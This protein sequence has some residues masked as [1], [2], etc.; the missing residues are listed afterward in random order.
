MAD[1]V[2]TD[3]LEKALNDLAEAMGLS[4]KEF[5]EGGFLDKATYSEDHAAVVAR[6]DA[7]DVVDSEDD[8]ESIAEKL[9]AVRKVLS[10]DDGALQGI[11]NL[12]KEN[13]AAI[14]TEKDRAE[15]VEAGLRTDVDNATAKG[16]SNE[17]AIADLKTAT[18]DYATA[19]D[20]RVTDVEGRITDTEAA[21]NTLNADADTAGSVAKAVADEAARAK[22]VSGALA[23]LT[24]DEKD[25]LV[26]AINEVDS[27][28]K[29]N[30]AGI[31]ALTDRVGT[32]E[33]TLT[34]LNGD[35]SVTGSVTQ[36]VKGLEDKLT[37]AFTDAMTDAK[38][39]LDA[40]DANLQAQITTLNADDETEGSV[41]YK[42]KQATGGDISDL[43]DRMDATE[44]KT[45]AN[46]S[47]VSLLNSDSETEGS[48]DYKIAQAANTSNA[49]TDALDDRIT[50]D[51]AALATLNGDD[52][53]EGSVAKQVKDASDALTS[54]VEANKS[55]IEG[56]VSELTDTV[57][58]N[59]TA[60][61]DTIAANATTAS[62]ALIAESKR[63]TDAE[64]AL[65]GRTKTV[66]DILNDTTDEDDNL[67]KGIVTRVGDT[68]SALAAQ[69]QKQI[70]DLQAAVDEL[71]AYSDS[72]D[73][74]AAS[75]DICGVHNKF[76]S[77][78]G[79][80]DKDCGGDGDGEAV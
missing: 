69:A 50:A 31:S 13:Q 20:E 38:D 4:V 9:I 57:A 39:A 10:D 62:D 41:D 55:A 59:K 48:V 23:D 44:G 72:R 65:A 49:I 29:V 30:A 8:I 40:A 32:N 43:S 37:E 7:I 75:M 17:S 42:I 2:T 63:A 12:I 78:L 54:T 79:L 16:A 74:K 68:E 61:E 76:R 14:T 25:T 56:T 52:T 19:N 35:A 24:T 1:N 71:K 28:A 11:L 70:D 34:T 27:N 58:A 53:V 67:V 18:S 47:A 66:E 36:K 33:D 77:A 51:E 60:L 21:L 73:L 45:A 26:G 5:V 15:G 64:V 22:N 3:D 6:L 46:T 80:G